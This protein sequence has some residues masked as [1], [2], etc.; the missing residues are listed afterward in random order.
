MTAHSTLSTLLDSGG[1][2]IRYRVARELLGDARQARTCQSALLESRQVGRWLDALP[3][4]LPLEPL[5]LG[6]IHGG[7]E[8][9]LE[10]VLGKLIFLG[11]HAGIDVFGRRVAPVRRWLEASRE[12]ADQHSFGAFARSLLGSQLAL[13]GYRDAPEV[14]AVVRERTA[15]IDGWVKKG[16]L[17]IHVPWG[18][19]DRPTPFHRRRPLIDPTLYDRGGFALP[20]HHDL[21]LLGA[22]PARRRR[23]GPV[24]RIVARVL[25]PGFQALDWSYGMVRVDSR[26]FMVSGWQ[27]ALP[28][29]PSAP[30][31]KAASNLIAALLMM[32]PFPAARS[33][34]WFV[35]C[36]SH[37]DQFTDDDGGSCFPASYLRDQRSG[38][39]PWAR[40]RLED[41]RNSPRTRRLESTFWRA[42]L[43]Q[44]QT[45]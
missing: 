38:Y 21:H 14:Q 20:W 35:A 6:S 7:G 25:E 44:L 29:Y 31:G 40:M 10:T 5:P 23:G 37:L 16:S 1:P 26:R 27:P 13:A 17:Q 28:G 19:D 39:W 42:K 43:D 15:A 22:L 18:P 32:A 3:R 33:H 11:L 41:A 36:L 45:T 34:S 24:Q 9:A 8:A 2:V 30:G 4:T 12:W